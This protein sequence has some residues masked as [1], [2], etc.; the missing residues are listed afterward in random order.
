[1]SEE[2][3]R[4]VRALLKAVS[5]KDLKGMED[6]YD[7]NLSY[8]GTG[9]MAEAG[10]SGFLQFAEAMLAAFPDISVTA[11]DVFSSG[12][13]VVYRLTLRGTHK[14]ELMGIP[15]TNKAVAVR[16]IGIARVSG[17][18]I[19]EEWENFDD[20]GLMQQ[21]GVVPPPGQS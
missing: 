16:S 8:H 6:V 11:D 5:R 20:M 17:G 18:K 2:H 9:D 15:A 1:M 4:V 3:E 21:L 14:A 13:K 19:V 12:D 10:R 7:P